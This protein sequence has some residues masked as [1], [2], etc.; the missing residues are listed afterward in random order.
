MKIYSL[1][2]I[3]SFV[4]LILTACGGGSSSAKLQTADVMKFIDV[5][6]E[7]FDKKV[8][9]KGLYGGPSAMFTRKSD[10]LMMFVATNVHPDG[11][12]TAFSDDLETAKMTL[13]SEA[14]VK[15]EQRN[16]KNVYAQAQTMNEM[17]QYKAVVYEGDYRF[18]FGADGKDASQI[19]E[20]VDK[21]IDKVT[22]N[23]RK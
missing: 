5:E 14:E 4:F 15:Q 8:D 23:L 17:N 2:I 13:S 9:E 7:D 18:V 20:A 11:E 16:G 22:A 1:S 6:L 3:A 12:G 21:L 10:R 19:K